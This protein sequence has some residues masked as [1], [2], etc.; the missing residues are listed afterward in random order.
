MISRVTDLVLAQS[1]VKKLSLLKWRAVA[2]MEEHTV[3]L[4]EGS[5]KKPAIT[6]VFV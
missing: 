6:N 2:L 4:L 1:T 3:Q 5:C